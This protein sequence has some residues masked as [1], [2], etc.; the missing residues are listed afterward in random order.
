[1]H[2]PKSDAYVK[3]YNGGIKWSYYL[4]GD[5]ELLK[6]YVTWN[7]LSNSMKKEFDSEHICDSV[8]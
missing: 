8:N 7:K 2:L 6:I 3:I 1:M 5:E 4:I